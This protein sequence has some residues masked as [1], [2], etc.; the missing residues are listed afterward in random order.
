MWMKKLKAVF[1]TND[2]KKYERKVTISHEMM[3]QA[4]DF[5]YE[6]QVQISAFKDLLCDIIPNRPIENDEFI[7]FEG[8]ED[9]PW[10]PRSNWYIS[11][12]YDSYNWPQVRKAFTDQG[13]SI[14]K[15][16]E[17][18]DS[19]DIDKVNDLVK[20]LYLAESKILAEVSTAKDMRMTFLEE[21]NKYVRVLEAKHSNDIVDKT[22]NDVETNTE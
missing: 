12:I 5:G 9:I 8:W 7:T 21:V 11:K 4:V 15:L 1:H 14:S 2:E 20:R 10:P 19:G 6:K 3:K 17:I 18:L 16:I 13:I 22:K